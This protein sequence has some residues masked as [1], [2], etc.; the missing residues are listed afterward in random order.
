MIAAMHQISS[1]HSNTHCNMSC[2][3]HTQGVTREVTTVMVLNQMMRCL[4]RQTWSEG[5][6]KV[7][8][9]TWLYKHAIMILKEKENPDSI[10]S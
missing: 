6:M 1:P 3:T 9:L 7:I 10:E 2:N 5:L 4:E 8:Q